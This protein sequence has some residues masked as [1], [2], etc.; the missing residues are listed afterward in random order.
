MSTGKIISDRRKALNLSQ[1]ELAARI[2]KADGTPIS[3]QYLNDIE[4]ERR[5]LTVGHVM[6][7]IAEELGIELDLLC[8]YSGELPENARLGKDASPETILKAFKAFRKVLA[9]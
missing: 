1:K 9:K 4:H 2:L 6:N 7:R 8:Y 3:P 5:L